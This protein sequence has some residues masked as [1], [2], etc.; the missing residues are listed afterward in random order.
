MEFHIILHAR[1]S[2]SKKYL[3]LPVVRYFSWS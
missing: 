2:T 1:Y 3:N